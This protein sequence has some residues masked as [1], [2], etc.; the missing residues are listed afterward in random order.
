MPANVIQVQYE[1]LAGVAAQFGRSAA[2]TAAVQQQVERSSQAL[3]QGGWEGRGSIAFFAELDGVTLPGLLRLGSALR[4]AQKVTLQ[5]GFLMRQ[6][7]EE[8]A[9]PFRERNGAAPAAVPDPAT[10]PIYDPS[11]DDKLFWGL[12]T[13]KYY[14]NPSYQLFAGSISLDGISPSD[15]KQGYLGDCYFL[16]ALASVAQQHPE[17]IWNAIKDNGD[18][19]YT[20]TFYQDGKPVPVTVDAEFPVT[21]DAKGNPTGTPAYA[22]TGS[23]RDELWPLIMEKAYAQLDGG[24]YRKIEGGWPG[25]AVELLTGAS[26]QRLDLAAA[27][28]GEA[29]LRLE[30][31]QKSAR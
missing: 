11:R 20:V 13:D 1:R 10:A 14:Y 22:R 8:A 29:R 27:T 12:F 21:E 31:L 24:S 2:S 18:G 19:T 28:A 15:I 9:R 26:P 3:R 17:V 7:E 25:E 30:A 16:A 4:E 6:A 23:T 5:I